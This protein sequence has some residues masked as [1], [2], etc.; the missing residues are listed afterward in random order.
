MMYESRKTRIYI[1]SQGVKDWQYLLAD[2]EKQWKAGYSA[3]AL[4]YCWEEYGDF[5]TEIRTIFRNCDN[6]SLQ[7]PELLMAIP[8]YK[9]NLPG[10]SRPSQNDIFVLAKAED[11]LISI[12]IEG[13]VHESFGDTLG[14]WLISASEG[15]KLRLKYLQ[16]SLALEKTFPEN[17]RYQLIHR[18]ASSV[19]EAENLEDILVS[20][21]YLLKH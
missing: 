1:P 11:G 16:D 9:V 19:I 4:A 6:E 8:E 12:T 7:K 20:A 13:K 21:F 15:K 10:G 14:D 2:P 5:P 18:M 3:A 17:I